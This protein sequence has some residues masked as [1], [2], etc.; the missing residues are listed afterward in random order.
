MRLRYQ[1]PFC[2]VVVGFAGSGL[3]GQHLPA[4]SPVALD[5]SV[6]T[7]ENMEPAIPRP[8]QDKAVDEKLATFYK[9]TGK[10][11]NILWF[12]ET[13]AGRRRC[14]PTLPSTDQGIGR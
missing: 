11:P 4:K 14:W 13:W 9:K 7:T 1:L 5:R 3:T 12:V 8:E 6:R 2:L 10:R